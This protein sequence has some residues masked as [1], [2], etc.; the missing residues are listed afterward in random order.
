M[1][2]SRVVEDLPALVQ[3]GL[4]TL[5]LSAASIALALV[6][7]IAIGL[8]RAASSAILRLPSRAFVDVVRGTP[9]LIQLYILYFGLP[10][11]GIRFEPFT[12]AVI[13]L[14]VNTAAYIAEI[15]RAA[16]KSVPKQHAESARALGLGRLRILSRIVAPQALVVALPAVTNELVDIVKWSSVAAVVV[17]S[18]MTQVF[19]TIVG[20]TFDLVELFIVVALFYLAVTVS[21][22]A[23]LRW[24]EFRLSRY[25]VMW[26]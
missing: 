21:L 11:L 8:M 2:W 4:T 19:Y 22:S 15:L 7:G 10:S 14:G 13:A 25:R 23:G 18:E 17:V 26:S 5:A 1:H 6:L 24:L 3:G 16:I 9:L 20:R 12:A